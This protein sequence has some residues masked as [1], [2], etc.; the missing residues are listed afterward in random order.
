[1]PPSEEPVFI[2]DEGKVKVAEMVVLDDCD[3][4]KL[5]GEKILLS[6]NVFFVPQRPH[7]DSSR[8]GDSDANVGFYGR[9]SGERVNVRLID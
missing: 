5:V 8:C 1:M 6:K 3:D 2:P 7:V 9:I 4:I